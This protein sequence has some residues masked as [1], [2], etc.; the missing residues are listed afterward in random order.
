MKYVQLLR[1]TKIN[2]IIINKMNKYENL[3]EIIIT[4][5]QSLNLVLLMIN[6]YYYYHLLSFL[7][8]IKY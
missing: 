2:E 4:I 1:K 8:L 6:Y 3:K 5:E 7:L